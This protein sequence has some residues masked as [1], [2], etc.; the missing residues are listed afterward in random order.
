MPSDEDLKK[1]NETTA[2][3]TTGKFEPQTIIIDGHQ[4][5]LAYLISEIPCEIGGRG[6]V[7]YKLNGKRGNGRRHHVRVSDRRHECDCTCRDF[8]KNNRCKHLNAL[9]NLLNL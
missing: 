9:L 1:P 2:T 5:Q 8:V 6:F 4:G 7:V 3:T